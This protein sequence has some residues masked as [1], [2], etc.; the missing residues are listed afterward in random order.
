MLLPQ[1]W[2]IRRSF[3]W[4]A[5]VRRLA[6]DDERLPET[7]AVVHFLTFATLMFKRFVTFMIDS[8]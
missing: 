3:T 5:C 7:P 4:I 1:R 2:T 6:R 8:S